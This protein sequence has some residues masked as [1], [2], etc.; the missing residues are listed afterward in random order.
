MLLRVLLSKWNSGARAKPIEPHQDKPIQER[1]TRPARRLTMQ[2]ESCWRKVRISASRRELDL[3]SPAKADIKCF[4]VSIIKGDHATIPTISRLD[5]VFGMDRDKRH[6][7]LVPAEIAFFKTANG[8]T[9][10]S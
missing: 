3:N 2:T 5:P 4:N 10:Q 9:W 1:D 8:L 6:Q 7:L